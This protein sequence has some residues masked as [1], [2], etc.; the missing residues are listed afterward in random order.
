MKKVLITGSEGFAGQH[1]WQELQS[2]GYD[3]YGTTLHEPEK[4][5]PE[6]V[7]VCDI[8]SQEQLFAL[9][10]LL[11]PD[12]IVHLAGQPKPGLS[13]NIPQKTFQVNTI[14]TVNLLEAVRSIAGYKPRLLL[15]GTSEEHGVV[16]VEELPITEKSP[17]NPI[18]PYAISKL[19]NWF[20]AKEYVRSFGF[21]IVYATPFTHTGPG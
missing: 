9:I 21:D 10:S 3:V 20:L 15:V 14:G 2:H 4:G 7:S 5:L 1:L 6:H 17:L 11:K 16:P 19:A 13:F 12:A 8:E 18:N